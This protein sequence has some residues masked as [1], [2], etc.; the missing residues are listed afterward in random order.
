M[1]FLYYFFHKFIDA[2]LKYSTSN[3]FLPQLELVKTKTKDNPQK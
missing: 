3:N 1:T 2:K